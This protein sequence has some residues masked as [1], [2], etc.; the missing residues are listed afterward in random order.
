[1]LEKQEAAKDDIGECLKKLEELGWGEPLHGMALFILA[2]N[3]DYRKMW[4]R[5][6]PAKCE[7]WITQLTTRKYGGNV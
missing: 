5:L 7:S 3:P 2:E 1:M 4:M 6:E